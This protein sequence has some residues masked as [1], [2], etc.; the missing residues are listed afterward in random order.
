MSFDD[1]RP[2]P[3]DAGKPKGPQPVLVAALIFFDGRA[4]LVICSA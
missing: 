1:G 3:I 2:P 4:M